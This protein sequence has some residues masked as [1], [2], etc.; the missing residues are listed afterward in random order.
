MLPVTR[1]LRPVVASNLPNPPADVGE[2]AELCL[3]PLDRLVV[4]D[5]YQRPIAKAG[6][7]SILRILANFDWRKFTPIVVT[8]LGDGTFAIIDGQHRAT[9]ALM[10]PGIDMAPCMVIKVS[11]E[12]AA[13][14]FAAING[15][16][17]AVTPCQ[18]YAARLAAGDADATALHAVLDKA[19]VT[20]LRYRFPGTPWKV[21]ETMA[22]GTLESCLAR[23]GEPALSAA[24]AAVVRSRKG[25][26]GCLTAGVIT[27]LCRLM[28]DNPL[29][30][31]AGDR[32]IEAIGGLRLA[33]VEHEAAGEAKQCGKPR[34]QILYARLHKQ[35]VTKLGPGAARTTPESSSQSRDIAVCDPLDAARRST[36]A[37]RQFRDGGR[38]A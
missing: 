33:D 29:W 23:Y 19:G 7:T 11:P 34:S 15:Q 37:V 5:R 12:E 24:L 3:L 38:R 36:A 25:N 16:V 32:M 14:C 31:T 27:A 30:C 9:A 1:K 10:H 17:T 2:R 22:I 8:P 28:S 13:A 35:L 20:V 21:G 4:D 6:R 26:P 18:I